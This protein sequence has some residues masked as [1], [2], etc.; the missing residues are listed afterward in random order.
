MDDKAKDPNFNISQFL[1]NSYKHPNFLD[2]KPIEETKK[3]IKS[4]ESKKLKPITKKNEKLDSTID[5]PNVVQNYKS[6]SFTIFEILKLV[7]INVLIH[8]V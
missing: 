4:F 1:Q 8:I 3:T 6:I 7:F 5:I 2:E